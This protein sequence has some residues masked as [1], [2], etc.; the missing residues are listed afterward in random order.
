MALTHPLINFLPSIT[1]EPIVL[2]YMLA[3]M[4]EMPALQDLLF[5]RMCISK[6]EHF[7]YNMSL[8]DMM[9]FCDRSRTP[10]GTT[11]R[12]KE[13]YE[14]IKADY[15]TYWGSYYQ[16]DPLRFGFE[17]LQKDSILLYLA[18]LTHFRDVF[19]FVRLWLHFTRDPGLI[20]LDARHPSL[21]PLCYLLSPKFCSSFAQSTLPKAILQTIF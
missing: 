6:L 2:L 4:A 10:N 17:M 7:G 14:E 18:F 20:N 5:S 21:S 19:F 11:Q 3:I 16:V 15:V 1:V 9:R 12:E 8:V 13:D